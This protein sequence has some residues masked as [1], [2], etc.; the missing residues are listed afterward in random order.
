[1]I[2]PEPHPSFIEVFCGPAV[3]DGHRQV[4]GRG[5]MGRPATAGEGVAVV[6]LA[7]TNVVSRPGIENPQ[8]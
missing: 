5:R 6:N 2:G 1:M 8:I 7:R 4:E 3:S